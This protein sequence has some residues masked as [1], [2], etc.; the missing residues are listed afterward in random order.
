M[1]QTAQTDYLRLPV[2]DKANL[3]ASEKATIKRWINDGIILDAV[4]TSNSDKK[5]VRVAGYDISGDFPVIIMG[6]NTSIDV[7]SIVSMSVDDVSANVG[8]VF[9]TGSVAESDLV[10][11]VFDAKLPVGTYTGS[12]KTSTETI[13]SVSFAIADDP[14]KTAQVAVSAAQASKLSSTNILEVS[15]T[16]NGSVKGEFA[17]PAAE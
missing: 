7:V 17:A 11:V 14:G 15:L 13:S 2:A 10:K 3:G 8:E 4:I 6:D 1:P 5:Q 16:I 12:I 9:A